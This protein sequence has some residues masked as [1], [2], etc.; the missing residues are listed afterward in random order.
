MI[1]DQEEGSA[2]KANQFLF[3]LKAR[4]APVHLRLEGSGISRNLMA[5]NVTLKNYVDYLKGMRD[6][7]FFTECEIFPGT[8]QVIDDIRDRKKIQWVE[9][10]LHHF[11]HRDQANTK[12]YSHIQLSNLGEK[13]GWVYVVEGSTLGGRLILK[14]LNGKFDDLQEKGARFLDG[15]GADTGLR[16]KAFLSQLSTYAVENN[17][18]EEVI[19]GAVKAFDAIYQNFNV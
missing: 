18:E 10:D 5:E 14:F 12:A 15:Y 11:G 19:G 13:L 2:Q 17:Q 9:E 1:T 16:W 8:S 3:D 4:T 6:L 7:T